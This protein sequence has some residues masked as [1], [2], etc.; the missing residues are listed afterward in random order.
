MPD[1][2]LWLVLLTAGVVAGVMNTLAGG[3]SLLTLPALMLLGLPA[4]EANGTNRVGV[5]LQALVATGRFGA[6]GAVDWRELAR[7]ASPVVAGSVAGAWTSVDLDDVLLRRLVG[8]LLLVLLPTLLADPHSWL[9]GRG[10]PR[11]P[12][13][14]RVLVLAAI[15]FYGGFIQAGVGY[16]LLA[17][18]VLLQG[19][20]LVRA[21]AIKVVLA[22]V[23]TAP[24]LL[25]FMAYDLVRWGPGLALGAGTMV[26][27]EL[28][29]RLALGRGAALVRRVMVVCVVASALALILGG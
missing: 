9:E 29:A 10:T 15:G 19:L 22:L 13:W 14:L 21:N 11:G 28:G 20:D 27:A 25:V 4:A 26:G 6:A 12:G 23:F 24:A 1:W 2:A 7:V 8:V 3:G 18:L 16:F 5:V 17:S